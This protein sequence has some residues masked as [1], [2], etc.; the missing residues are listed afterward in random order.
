MN[1]KKEALI[2]LL[3]AF[4]QYQDA[5][6]AAHLGEVLW[7]LE[8]KTEAREV[9]LNV[10]QKHPKHKVLLQTIQKFD[11]ELLTPKEEASSP[12]TGEASPDT[13]EASP[14]N[15]DAVADNNET[16]ADDLAAPKK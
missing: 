15:S 3:K 4:Q 13:G 8:Q 12:D 16:D 2:F 9:W 11:P 6:I 1:Q 10:V 5:E 14:A 7:S